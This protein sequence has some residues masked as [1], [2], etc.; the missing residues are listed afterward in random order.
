MLMRLRARDSGTR[1]IVDTRSA[2]VYADPDEGGWIGAANRVDLDLGE[3]VLKSVLEYLEYFAPL[4]G[5]ATP[6]GKLEVRG[7]LSRTEERA[8]ADGQR[9]ASERPALL[10]HLD[11]FDRDLDGRITLAESYAAWRA[12]GF[13]V[14]RA[15]WKTLLSALVFGRW[16]GGFAIE[17][18]RIG[19]RRYA[20]SSGIFDRA[21]RIDT[22][23]LGACLAAFGANGELSFDAVIALLERCGADGK[24]SRTQFRS[25][26]EVCARLNGGRQVVTAAQFRG[27][28]DG[29]LLWL[30]ACTPDNAGRRAWTAR[31]AAA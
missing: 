26:F 25:L 11:F 31:A 15:S 21:G 24:V 5:N 29:S 10:L 7:A 14:L 9:V 3:R 19:E 28:F 20:R 1:F 23:R 12:L 13:P 8:F 4:P 30:A 6:D 22:A 16:R 2:G 18:D 27:L 17:V